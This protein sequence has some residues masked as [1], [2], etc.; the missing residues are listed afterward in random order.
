[1]MTPVQKAFIEDRRLAILR[2]LS[3]DKGYALNTAMLQEAL[4]AIGHNVSRDEVE[5]QAAWLAEQGLVEVEKVGPVTVA[6]LTERGLDCASGAA[7]V[8][9][10]KRPGP[11]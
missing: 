2:F 3:E 6:R 10:V 4:K 1:M 5:T 8:P 11:R 7:C 9:G